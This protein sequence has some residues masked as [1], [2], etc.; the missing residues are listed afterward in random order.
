MSERLARGDHRMDT[1]KGRRMT[2]PLIAA[3]L[4]IAPLAGIAADSLPPLKDFSASGDQSFGRRVVV[5]WYRPYIASCNCS[6]T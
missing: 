1:S 4:T 5:S 6:S 3:F 2:R